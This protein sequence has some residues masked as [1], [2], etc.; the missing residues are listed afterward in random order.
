M[1]SFWNLSTG[2]KI[3]LVV[4]A[5]LLII[6]GLFINYL[7]GGNFTALFAKQTSCEKVLSKWESAHNEDTRVRTLYQG[8]IA[9]VQYETSV[10][11]QAKEHA[12]SIDAAIQGGVN[13]SGN[14]A[15]AQ[16]E[17]GAQC[18]GHAIVN[19]ES[20]KIITFGPQSEAGVGIAPESNVLI[21]NP[22]ENFPSSIELKKANLETLLSLA[23]ML[24]EYY[25]L[26][27]EGDKARLQKICAESPFEGLIL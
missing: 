8:P 4:C 23:G 3:L 20:G 24:R 27:G 17:C 1:N 16:W 26:E 2:A 13:F 12:A 7:V 6:E 9:P 10:L 5:V 18:Q 11:P 25:V 14:Y 15:V 22:R 19:V 21:V